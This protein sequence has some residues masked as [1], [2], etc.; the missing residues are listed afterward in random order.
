[1][2]TA[3]YVDDRERLNIKSRKRKY[4]KLVTIL[5]SNTKL[6]D[7]KVLDIGTSAE[8][9]Q[10]WLS[11]D[12][13]SLTSVDVIDERK[14][15]KGY[16]FK[17]VADARLPFN[18]ESFDIVISSHVI[19][20]IPSQQMHLDEVNRVLKPGGI[21]YLS[22]PSRMAIIEPHYKLPLLSWLPRRVASTYLR[23]IRNKDWNVY[24]VSRRQLHRLINSR[25]TI[26]D[27]VPVIVKNPRKFSLDEGGFI[28]KFVG[29]LPEFLINTIS[30]F[31]PTIIWVLE[32]EKEST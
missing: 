9:I 4:K 23:L 1:M 12:V 28:A 24:P 25:L 15:K 18:D 22:T 11:A 30:G 17:Q 6:A 26:C 29:S 32:K 13:K 2:R 14:E 8:Y 16:K 10:S 31:S 21:V 19:E 7:K 5:K 27:M 20:H 3:A